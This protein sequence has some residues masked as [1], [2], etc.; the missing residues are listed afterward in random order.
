MTDEGS[1]QGFGQLIEQAKSGALSLRADPAAFIALA[2]ALNN[3]MN[4]IRD[5]QRA[6]RNIFDQQ[7]WGLGEKSEYLTS[8]QTIVQRFR[9]KAMTGPNN[10]FD[11][12]DGHFKV[13][14]DLQSTLNTIRERYEQTDAEFAARFKELQW[15]QRPEHGGGR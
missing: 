1:Q 15:A 3:R 14:T 10:A 2:K 4:E 7:D 5:I 8:A 9:E 11:I 6:I 13:A 12:L